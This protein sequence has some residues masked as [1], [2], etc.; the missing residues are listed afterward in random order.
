MGRH[1][2]IYGGIT[3]VGIND[4]RW[5]NKRICMSG[6]TSNTL[7]IALYQ[8]MAMLKCPKLSVG[9]SMCHFVLLCHL[10]NLLWKRIVIKGET[11]FPPWWINYDLICIP[12][13]YARPTIKIKH[14]FP[15]DM[16][17]SSPPAQLPD[18]GNSVLPGGVRWWYSQ[19]FTWTAYI[20]SCLLSTT[21]YSVNTR[22]KHNFGLNR[23]WSGAGDGARFRFG[24]FR[25]LT[26]LFVT[27]WF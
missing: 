4:A 22:Y 27:T 19:S 16:A 17:P 26:R 5:H 2:L 7:R 6:W 1:V 15:C 11:C 18:R 24:T 8:H 25:Y 3:I 14:T 12:M 23:T 9:L 10:E 20:H 13:R 21:R